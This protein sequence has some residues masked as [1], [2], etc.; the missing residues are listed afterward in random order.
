[1]K[2][3][4]LSEKE[5]ILSFEKEKEEKLDDI[6]FLVRKTSSNVDTNYKTQ[7]KLN[8]DDLFAQYL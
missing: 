3:K 1:M 5:T 7:D 4:I 8:I 6:D 2:D